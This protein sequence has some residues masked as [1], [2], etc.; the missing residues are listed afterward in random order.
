MIAIAPAP[1]RVCILG[2]TGFV[3]RALAYRLAARQH[4]LRILTRD[5]RRAHGLRVLPTIELVRADV[6]DLAT[7]ERAFRDI[8]TVVNL[9]GILN[10]RGRDG[11]GF[12][13]VHTELTGK[14][15]A[16]CQAAGVEQLL[17]MSALNASAERGPSHYLRSKGLAEAAIRERTSD[18]LNWTIF[19][20][21][22]IF[23]RD[24]AF[25]N[26]FAALLRRL[27]LPFPL[28]CAAAQFAPVYVEDVAEA[29]AR[30]LGHS[31]AS[32]QTFELCGPETWT[33]HEIVAFTARTLGL[34]RPIVPL[35]DPIARLQATVFD[36]VPGKPF[37][38]DNYLS[39]TIPSV[40]SEDGLA[41]LG[42]RPASMRAIVPTYLNADRGRGVSAP[43]A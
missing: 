18:G 27:P 22:V 11:A 24:D 1:R 10:E 32:G 25:V 43:S 21:S 6:H 16:A 35:P 34:T 12:R 30:C 15:V 23:G 41:R 42:I 4:R 14:I 8:D 7:L 20:P 2:G 26:K 28:A 13:H 17:Q 39:A 36:F 19:R 29:F 38:T 31:R 33:L 5:T 3:G 37:S 40:C 9:V